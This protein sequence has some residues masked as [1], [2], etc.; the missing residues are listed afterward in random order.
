MT[1][2]GTTGCTESRVT[3]RTT[4]YVIPDTCVQLE[5]EQVLEVRPQGLGP[6]RQDHLV[7][8]RGLLRQLRL[9]HRHQARPTSP[10]H[11]LTV[12]TARPSNLCVDSK[13]DTVSSKVSWTGAT[14]ANASSIAASLALLLV[15]LLV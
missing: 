14:K 7:R 2:Y 6:D 8:R 15:A 13:I 11:L 5:Q 9:H 12:L 4:T 10:P 1:N 3:S